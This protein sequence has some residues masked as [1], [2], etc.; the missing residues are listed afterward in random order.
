MTQDRIGI[1]FISRDIAKEL[2]RYG[3]DNLEDL[4]T[5]VISVV[6]GQGHGTVWDRTVQDMF[7]TFYV[8]NIFGT[9]YRSCNHFFYMNKV[10]LIS[11][12]NELK[13]SKIYIL[14]KNQKGNLRLFLKRFTN[15]HF[16]LVSIAG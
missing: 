14:Q 9:I 16:A 8:Q 10:A 15:I 7:Y 4:R 6:T 11:L 1:P 13:L 12:L 3:K 5:A 2:S